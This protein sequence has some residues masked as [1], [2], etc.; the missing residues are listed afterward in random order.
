MSYK[1]CTLFIVLAMAISAFAIDSDS[2]SDSRNRNTDWGSNYDNETN[3]T[4]V[5][6]IILCLK[7]GI[8]YKFPY[9][10]CYGQFERI[11]NDIPE[12]SPE[13]VSGAEDCAIQAVAAVGEGEAPKTIAVISVFPY[14]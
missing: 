7:D 9:S 10:V 13:V 11:A 4:I 14:I 1:K 8:Q 12:K 2:W 5:F 6:I 3:F